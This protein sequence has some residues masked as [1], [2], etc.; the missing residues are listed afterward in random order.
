MF[1]ANIAVVERYSAIESLVDLHFGSGE[2]E[3][4]WLG[5]NL[6]SLA[7]PLD[8]VVV[9]DDAL[10]SE[11][12]DAVE[13]I[14]SRAPGFNTVAW[15]AGE[16]AVV[17]GDELLQYGVGCRQIASVGET[18][19]AGEAVLQHAPET[20]DAAFGLGALRGDEGDAELFQSAT[21][22]RG[23]ALAGKLFV[24]GPV[25]VV[26]GEDAAAIAVEGQGGTP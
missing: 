14:R 20:L 6:Q 3:A 13:I 4:A 17:I 16:A 21:E 22:L 15:S 1:K 8:N 7:A 10:V 2:A 18:K 19:L 12:T 26:A 5:V 9:A 23:L 25:L 24:D 11:A